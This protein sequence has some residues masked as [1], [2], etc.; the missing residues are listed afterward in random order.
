ML[1]YGKLIPI[2]YRMF[3]E[4]YR[5]V[6]LEKQVIS[7]QTDGKWF[8]SDAIFSG[9]L[10]EV[11]ERY[12]NN[13]PTLVFCPTRDSAKK[14][15]EKLAA[16]VGKH[17]RF[18]P[19][20]LVKHPNQYKELKALQAKLQDK[21]LA[22]IVLS[23]VAFHNGGLALQDRRLIEGCFISGIIGAIC[24][25]RAKFI[26]GTTSTLAVGVNLPAHLVIIKGTV[27]YNG[28]E[29]T[30]YSEL[31]IMQMLGRAGRPQVLS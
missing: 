13:K 24:K 1:K 23:G 29:M 18:V 20:K 12:S 11:I 8:A 9:K 7:I 4:E 28:K 3:G 27:M 25:Y 15:A 26:I 5:P 22:D 30:E 19:T 16:D 10:F 6:K 21:K 2:K 31:D 14:S 17:D